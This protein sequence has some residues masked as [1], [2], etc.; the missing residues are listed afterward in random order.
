MKPT[1]LLPLPPHALEVAGVLNPTDY[2]GGANLWLTT[3]A[4]GGP[5]LTSCL[6][7]PGTTTRLVG[8]AFPVMQM[9]ELVSAVGVLGIR[10]RF[11]VLPDAKQPL[12][13]SVAL[14]AVG[15]NEV[16]LSSYYLAERYWQSGAAPLPVATPR[17]AN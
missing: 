13:F 9:V 3:R 16:V 2:Q 14:F 17:R 15:A 10:A 6:L 12:R 11:V 5:D 7:S 4:A 1:P 8:V